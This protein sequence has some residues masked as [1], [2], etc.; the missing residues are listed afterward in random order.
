M[1]KVGKVSHYFDKIGV[2]ALNLTGSLAV[3][4]TVKIGDLTQ[5]V[6]SMQIEHEQVEKAKKGDDVAIKVDSKVHE[7]QEVEKV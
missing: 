2:A 3:G 7:G 1:A 5:V 6:A 4:D